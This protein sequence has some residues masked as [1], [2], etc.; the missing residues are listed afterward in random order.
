MQFS[1]KLHVG[2]AICIIAILRHAICNTDMQYDKRVP[3]G[4]AIFSWMHVGHAIMK[5]Q[6]WNMWFDIRTW[7]CGIM[8]TCI[9]LSDM[10]VEHASKVETCGLKSNVWRSSELRQTVIV[11]MMSLSCDRD[12][13]NECPDIH[14]GSAPTSMQDMRVTDWEDINQWQTCSLSVYGCVFCFLASLWVFFS[15]TRCIIC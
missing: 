12:N 10:Q 8:W 11:S 6:I 15:K 9:L 13:L 1:F 4:H 14:D 5:H 2:H 3:Y 7:R